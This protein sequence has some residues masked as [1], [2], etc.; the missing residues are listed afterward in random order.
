MLKQFLKDAVAWGFGL[1]LIGY[2]LGILLFAIVPPA[3]IGWVIMPV[4]VLIAL[5]IL[6]KKVKGE[7]FRYYVLLALVWVLIAVV[8]D[9]FFL[10]KAFKP[11]DGY[12]KLDVYLYYA[13]TFI[14]PLLVG[15]RKTTTRK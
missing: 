8:C 2:V 12:Y 14:L 1:W 9:Y 6:W 4:G 3:M 5:W 11:A 10:V 7:S 13:L 15:W